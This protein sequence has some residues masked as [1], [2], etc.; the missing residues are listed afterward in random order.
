MVVKELERG[1]IDE[2]FSIIGLDGLNWKVELCENI[3]VEVL[4]REVNFRLTSKRKS[5]TKV[6][7]I[8]K[9]D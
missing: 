9:N 7:E 1:R 2:L 3:S 8:I 6:R 5:S 4:K